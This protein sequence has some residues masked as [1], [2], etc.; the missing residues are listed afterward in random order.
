MGGGGVVVLGMLAIVVVADV[1]CA[2]CYLVLEKAS[3]AWL[4]AVNE[5][6]GGREQGRGKKTKRRQTKR[7]Y[8]QNVE[9]KQLPPYHIIK[10]KTEKPNPQKMASIY[11][12]TYIHMYAHFSS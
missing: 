6:G 2:T 4:G 10:T 11:T 1:A 8:I 3:A 5:G 7:K 9:G 12:Y